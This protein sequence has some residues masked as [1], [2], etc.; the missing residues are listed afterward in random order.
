VHIPEVAGDACWQPADESSQ[1]GIGM[2][3]TTAVYSALVQIQGRDLSVDNGPSSCLPHAPRISLIHVPFQGDCSK[4][5]GRIAIGGLPC[6]VV[7]R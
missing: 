6:Q 1:N 7:F 3:L 2:F 5:K 4:S